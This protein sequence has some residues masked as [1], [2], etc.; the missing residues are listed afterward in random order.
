MLLPKLHNCW[1]WLWQQ[2]CNESLSA[3]CSV[4]S[5]STVLCC[6]MIPIYTHSALPYSSSNLKQVY[7][8]HRLY[9]HFPHYQLS[10]LQA[11]DNLHHSSHWSNCWSAMWR[12]FPLHVTTQDPIDTL[13]MVSEPLMMILVPGASH[14]EWLSSCC[15]L[16]SS[17][18]SCSI[19]L[20]HLWTICIHYWCKPMSFW[21][22]R[23]MHVT[24]W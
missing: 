13:H 2:L 5:V 17:L 23:C 20:S 12:I 11:I 7:I 21:S 4:S 19:Q 9:P 6:P 10:E 3:N 1:S 16:Q 15:R 14:R 8:L 22:I 24:I 18:Y